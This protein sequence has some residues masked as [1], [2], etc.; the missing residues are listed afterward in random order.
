MKTY[1]REVSVSPDDL[2]PNG[3]K[4]LEV[5]AGCYRKDEKANKVRQGA[6]RY[7]ICYRFV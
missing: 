7:T 1:A 4:V 2:K 5:D 3:Q 6:V